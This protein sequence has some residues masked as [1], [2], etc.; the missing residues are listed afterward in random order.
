MDWLYRFRWSLLALLLIAILLIL[1]NLPDEAERDG[2]LEA[3]AGGAS[4]LILEA[5]EHDLPD[6]VEARCGWFIPALNPGGHEDLRLPVLALEAGEPAPEATM[7][8]LPGGPGAP[9]GTG[10]SEASRWSQWL[11]G[12]DWPARLVVFDPRGTGH[13]RPD[14]HCPGHPLGQRAL[15]AEDLDPVAEAQAGNALLADCYRRQREA[16]RDPRHFDT[17]MMQ[18]DALGLVDALEAD[19]VSLIGVSHGS[20]VALQL[21]RGHPYRFDAAVLD[22]V[23]PPEKDPFMTLPEVHG[24]AVDRFFEQ[25]RREDSCRALLPEGR[26]V[27]EGLLARLDARPRLIFVLPGEQPPVPLQLNGHRFAGLFFAAMARGDDLARLPRALLDAQHGDFRAFAAASEQ[28]LAAAL[29]PASSRP[30]YWASICSETAPRPDLAGFGQL[31]NRHGAGSLLSAAAAR[32]FPC[33]GSWPSRDAGAASRKPVTAPVPTLFL[34][35]EMD[36]LTPAAWAHE[37]AER[38]PV[39]SSVEVARS[40]HG[41]LFSHRCAERVAMEF[42]ADPHGLAGGK[43]CAVP[44]PL[45]AMAPFGS[46]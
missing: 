6:G 22:G 35:G 13:A 19:T 12:Q 1:V 38:F 33:L 18:A 26:A 8:F 42:L 3:S 39:A 16:G 24:A 41:Q 20:R 21:L 9:G 46:D 32:E 28:T 37:Q 7:L 2:E 30:V 11:L 45:F 34:A 27:L 5:C 15:L 17:A 25:C 44:E 23:F 4:H 36:P 40:S 14:L 43:D 29:A 31:L 10:E